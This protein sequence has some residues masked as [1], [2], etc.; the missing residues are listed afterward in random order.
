MH[1]KRPLE[2]EPFWR[3]SGISIM[4]TVS[5]TSLLLVYE[6][7]RVDRH[8]DILTELLNYLVGRN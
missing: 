6:D 8:V 4:H 1:N 3:A 5:I 2:V 7:T